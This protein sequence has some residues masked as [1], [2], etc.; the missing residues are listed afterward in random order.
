MFTADSSV[1][2]FLNE[3]ISWSVK[4]PAIVKNVDLCFPQAQA[5][6]ICLVC[7]R[8]KDIKFTVIEH[9]NDSIQ[10]IIN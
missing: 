5:D 6:A 9:E 2:D 3:S 10:L 7:T 1:D 8:P 4:C